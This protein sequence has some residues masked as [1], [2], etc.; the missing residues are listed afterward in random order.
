MIR[1]LVLGCFWLLSAATTTH[2]QSGEG[3]ETLRRFLDNATTLRADFRQALY[4]AD[5]EEPQVSEGLLMI[6]RPGRFRWEYTVPEGQLVVCDGDKVWM[7]DEELEQVTVRPVDDTLRGTPAMLLSG[8]TTLDETFEI[9][10]SYEEDGRDWVELRPLSGSPEFSSL[11]IGLS[12]GALD[13]M[14]LRDSLG[15]MTRIEFFNLQSGLKLDDSLFEFVPPAGAD[16]IGQG[17][18]F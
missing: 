4:T 7:Y 1:F 3:A 6:K 18:D 11:R 13:R 2:A 8:Q 16:V 12:G 17:G 5:S 15:Q 9:I 10:G 14:E